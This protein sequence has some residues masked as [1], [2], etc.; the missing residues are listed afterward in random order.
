MMGRIALLLMLISGMVM[1]ASVMAQQNEMDEKKKKKVAV[2]AKK[3]AGEKKTETEGALGKEKKK[4]GLIPFGFPFY[5]PDTSGA[6]AFALVFYYNQDPKDPARKADELSLGGT[7]TLRNQ[8]AL[9]L[10]STVYFQNDRYKLTASVAGASYPQDFW[11]V[12][13]DTRDYMKEKYTP[14]SF[15]GQPGFLFKIVDNLYMGPIYHAS[16]VETH[17]KK[18][19]HQLRTLKIPGSDGTFAS[20]FGVNI[21]FDNRDS[22]FYPHRGFYIDAR[23]LVYRREFGSEYNFTRLELDFRPFVQLY[24]DLVLAFQLSARLNWGTVPFMILPQI[25]GMERMRGYA[26][27]RYMDKVCLIGQT[28]FRFPLV[29]RFGGVVFGSIGTVAPRLDQINP[30]FFRYAWGGGLRFTVDKSEHINFRLDVGVDE[31]LEPSFYF[32]IKEAF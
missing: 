8:M 16:Y 24:Q 2:A 27:G 7:Y 18:T 31:N 29:W 12:G 22:T 17:G 28:E 19:L 20:G 14:V 13:P 21:T 1:P 11:G 23:V 10:D 32:F 26:D 15:D 30:Y 4:W 3:P 25:G 9:K 5:S 6:L